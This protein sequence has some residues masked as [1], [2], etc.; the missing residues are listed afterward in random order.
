MAEKALV[1]GGGGVTGI[2]WEI[3]ILAGLG[4]Y[5]I[6]LT[7]ADL[8]VGTS[9]G[10]VVGV[11]VRSGA[12]LAELYK[13]QTAPPAGEIVAKMP[14]SMM[15]KYGRALLF[16]SNPVVGRR[17]VGAMA[18]RARTEPEATRRTVI[19]SRIPITEWPDRKLVITAVD[20]E[21]GEFTVFDAA[22]GADLVD[23]V[24]ASCA[25]PGIWPPVT[26]N[27]RRYIDGGMRSAA[28]AD[29]AA[30]HQRVVVIAPL[31]QGLGNV[32]SLSK[33]LH[34]L[35]GQGTQVAVI[36]PDKAA[37]AAIGRN[38]LDPARRPAAALAGFAQASAEA[39]A[40]RALWSTDPAA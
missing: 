23:A 6:D 5:G 20:A 3:G 12:T 9:A 29:L 35:T 34:M 10:S 14:L 7:D 30:G 8:V 33:Q 1:L 16:T 38:V 18:L 11:D 2:A 28:N 37:L 36:K 27:G 40:V 4:S 25:V 32:T 24:G 15:L 21:T 39:D 22:S 17:R 13:A 31:S 19:E 26:I